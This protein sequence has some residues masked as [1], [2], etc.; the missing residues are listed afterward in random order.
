[1]PSA[2]SHL[3]AV[4]NAFNARLLLSCS[5]IAFSQ[6]NFGFDSTAF[7]ATQA[8]DAFAET[9]GVYNTTTKKWYLESTYLSLL[10]ALPFI[11]FGAGLFAGSTVSARF[12]RRM[13]MFTMSVYA[14]ISVP[15][16]VLSTSKEQMLAARIINFAYLGMELSVVPIFQAEIVPPK[17]RG[18]VV[19]TY[20][21]CVY[22]GGVIMSIV[23]QSTAKMQGDLQWRIPLALFAFVP[24]VVTVLIWFIPESPRWLLMHGRHED[25]LRSL[26]ILRRG[27]FT[28]EEIETEFNSLQIILAE[29]HEQGNF[30]EIFQGPNLKRTWITVGI[31]FFLQITGQVFTSRYGT[32][33]IKSLGTVDPFIMTIVNQAVNLIG[34]LFSMA[35]VDSVGRRPLLIFSGG[36]QAASLFAMGGLGTP[37]IITNAMKTGV[38]ALITVFNFGFTSGLAPL[39]HTISAEI[40]TSRLRDMTYRTASAVN[41]LV[42]LVVTLV[43]P[44]LLDAP[45][46]ALGSK[47]GFI[48]G[49]FAICSMIFTYFCIPECKGKTL[50]EID[51][52]FIEKVPIR[53]FKHTKLP[54]EFVSKTTEEVKSEEVVQ[55]ECA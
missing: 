40:P 1:M 50:E 18:L 31:N 26:R 38:V 28:D 15:I 9:F 41:V 44:Y 11:G 53:K 33:Y 51:R 48:F 7:Q 54:V 14:L 34:I 23:C 17:V 5:L 43:I 24:L 25:S 21:L 27:K 8:M 30:M 6:M 32:I 47:V 45:Y 20:Q 10:N 36:L 3:V 22:I 2:I 39:S 46:A 12:G 52:L 49:S 35:F 16:T 4:K 13:V 42:Q 19:A 37:K 29:E 55:V